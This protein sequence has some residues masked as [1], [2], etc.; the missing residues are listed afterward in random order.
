MQLE[1][2]LNINN[3]NDNKIKKKFPKEKSVIKS[4]VKLVLQVC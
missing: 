3:N 2:G 1:N 4:E